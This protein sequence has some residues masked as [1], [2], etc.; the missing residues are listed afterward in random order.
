MSKLDDL[1]VKLMEIEDTINCYEADGDEEAKIDDLLVEKHDLE[2]EIRDLEAKPK[3]PSP[4]CGA[5]SAVSNG[6]GSWRC[7]QCGKKWK[8]K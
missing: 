7:G 2:M 4:C 3:M 6:R 8:A 5:E 1:K